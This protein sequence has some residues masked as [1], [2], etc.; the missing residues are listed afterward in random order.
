MALRLESLKTL[1]LRE[2][3]GVALNISQISVIHRA[4]QAGKH[5]H[6]DRQRYQQKQREKYSTEESYSNTLAGGVFGI[7]NFIIYGFSATWFFIYHRN[8]ERQEDSEADE[9]VEPREFQT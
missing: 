4:F 5:L 9:V 7:L 1:V 3:S 2:G 8:K 6:V